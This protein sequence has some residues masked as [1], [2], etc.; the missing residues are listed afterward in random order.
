MS[1]IRRGR[2]T[3]FTFRVRPGRYEAGARTR[4]RVRRIGA[5]EGRSKRGLPSATFGAE[6]HEI[7][8]VTA[9][10]SPRLIKRL[11]G[12]RDTHKSW[13]E[14]ETG[15]AY[16]VS[17][18]PGW[19]ARRMTQVYDLSDPTAPVKIRDFGLPGQSG[20]DR[21]GADGLHGPISMGRKQP[22]LF[23]L[24]DRQGRHPADRRSGEALERRTR[25][26]AANLGLQ[27][28]DASRSR[29]STGAYGI[30]AGQ[31]ESRGVCARQGR[32]RARVRDDRGRVGR[33]RMSG[34]AP[35]GVVRR[36]DGGSEADGR[37]ELYRRG[38]E[39]TLLRARR[40]LRLAFIE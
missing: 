7:W 16:L 31:D 27:K 18:V 19:R 1:W 15:I 23:W 12:L 20:F 36:R 21:S 40:T 39:W 37:V 14:C 38:V 11:P 22:D 26:T 29:R 6:A 33:Q 25:P 2:D 5:A 4:R 3:C 8:N 10:E 35:D 28:S 9:P 34:A 24:R 32:Q 30:S 13:W 17:G